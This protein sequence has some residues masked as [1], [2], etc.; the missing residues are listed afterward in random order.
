MNMENKNKLQEK[1]LWVK[2]ESRRI[3]IK[4]K[5]N[6]EKVKHTNLK[7]GRNTELKTHY[8]LCLYVN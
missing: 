1:Y 8:T 4:K 6:P 5:L 7:L 2:T 3:W